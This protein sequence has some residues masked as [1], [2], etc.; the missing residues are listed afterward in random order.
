[1]NH[2]RILKNHLKEP[3]K[4]AVFIMVA[5][6]M[7]ALLG[8]A[9]LAIDVGFLMA[10][11]NELQNAADAGALAGARVLYN[12]TGTAVNPGANQV[13]YDT[14]IRNKSMNEPVE[15]NWSGENTGDVQRGH[16]CFANKTFTPNDSLDP[17]D[18]W[19][20]SN[21]E[22]D[23]NMDF[24][25]AVRVTARRE[26]TPVA[27]FFARIFGKDDFAVM[28]DAVAYLGF[29][30]TLQPGEVDQPIVLCDTAVTDA[31]GEYSCTIG[32][33]LDTNMQTGAWTS[34]EQPCSG[35]ANAGEIAQLTCSGGNP[36]PIAL[37]DS[38]TT[39]E[40]TVASAYQNLLACWK[41]YISVNGYTPWE[42]TL[43]VIAC[44]DDGPI[45]NCN[46]PKGA[47]TVNLLWMTG[48]GQPKWKDAPTVM[49]D[50]DA[51][52]ADDITDVND[53][54]QR[55][56]SFV[57]HFNLDVDLQDT[58]KGF[59]S[60]AM[61]FKPNCEP[62]EMKGRSGGENFGILAKIPALVQ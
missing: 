34:F 57:N 15:V 1:M 2:Q 42:I 12:D 5:A 62:H 8:F 48:T 49:G 47:V 59:L 32:R 27:A 38:M 35:A 7:L 21:E 20:V 45:G 26:A 39:T 56:V 19:D 55:W 31:T 52:Q 36:E 11:R 53:G 9:A 6:A 16:W 28:A 37:G 17:V 41:D 58:K 10:S 13:A 23:S 30:G 25:N 33:M 61:Y 40:G 51:S 14:A 22:L 50:W 4:G 3:Q 29:T 54:E 44:N 46:T 24:I 18:L 60:K 43:P